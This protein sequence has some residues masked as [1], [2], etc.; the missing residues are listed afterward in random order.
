MFQSQKPF[1]DMSEPGGGLT[2][3]V[4]TLTD[5][6]KNTKRSYLGVK[7][8]SNEIIDHVQTYIC[9]ILPKY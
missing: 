4:I 3:G 7:F 8:R 6:V 1:P 2:G 5:T 9:I